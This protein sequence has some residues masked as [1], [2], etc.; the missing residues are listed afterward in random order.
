MFLALTLIGVVV[1]LEP[2]PLTAFILI[3]S[4]EGGRKKGLA[5]ILGWLLSLTLVIAA[6]I[7]A[8]GNQPPKPSTPP[9]TGILVGKLVIGLFLIYL[10]ERQRRRMGR[11]RKPPTWTARLDHLSLPLAAGFG[12]F[13]Q[14][15]AVVAAGA[16]TVANAKLSGALDYLT[17]VYFVLLSTSTYLAMELYD[18]FNH[19][20]ARA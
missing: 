2:I 18:V 5:Y 7:L 20:K 10:A 11:P 8:T 19:E 15:W 9:S 16:A 3:L 6:V 4:A 13:L 1:A 17:L 12:I 14:P